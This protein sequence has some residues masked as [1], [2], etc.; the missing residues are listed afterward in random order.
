MA[1]HQ[2]GS[3]DTRYH[4]KVFRGFVTFVTRSVI[5]IVVSLVLLAL[6]NG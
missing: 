3:M 1:E 2:H 6:I 5:V 4:E